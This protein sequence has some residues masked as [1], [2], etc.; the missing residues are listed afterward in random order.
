VRRADIFRERTKWAVAGLSFCLFVPLFLLATKIH[1]RGFPV[2]YTWTES[3]VNYAGG[4][5]RRGLLGE[6]AYN[7]DWLIPAPFFI[8]AIVLVAYLFVAGWFSLAVARGPSL[9]VVMLLL[10][11]A[12]ILFPIYNPGAFGR[13]D[14]FI[15]AALLASIEAAKRFPKYAL[16]WAVGIYVGVGLIIDTAWFYF[17]IAVAAVT[18]VSQQ[19]DS[20]AE[21][22]RRDL[23][24]FG[25]WLIALWLTYGWAGASD[26]TSQ[27][28]ASSWRAAYP[29]AFKFPGALYF[30]NS[31][32]ETTVKLVG[33][34]QSS[35]VT[36]LGYGLCFAFATLPLVLIR[37]ERFWRTFSRPVTI[38]IA[39]GVVAMLIP[40]A[41]A[42]DWGR[43]IHLLVMNLFALVFVASSPK[44]EPSK[45]PPF[46]AIGLI[47]LLLYLT[48]WQMGIFAPY[49]KTSFQPGL[50]FQ[51]DPTAK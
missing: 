6:V 10:S 29:E 25:I 47:I 32:A 39:F 8:T 11:P 2:S 44:R 40:F 31:S 49:G 4:Y 27:A 37:I 15:V 21:Q 18:M 22:V 43:L 41:V 48:T 50:V 51:L 36:A 45:A 42:L 13:K 24:A 12:T 26:E 38:T 5:V 30:L 17:P 34:H 16:A 28:I 3:M 23:I 19:D 14:I 46:S 33:R 1:L 9:G 20:P 35:A 7:L